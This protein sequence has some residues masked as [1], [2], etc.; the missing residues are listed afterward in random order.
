MKNFSKI[1][2]VLILFI[3]I[4]SIAFLNQYS[5]TE[6]SSEEAI[7]PDMLSIKLNARLYFVFGD[8]LHFEDRIIEFIDK[9]YAGGLVNELDK[10]PK[11]KIYD[12]LFNGDVKI[13]FLELK[14]RVAYID[15][16]TKSDNIDI[17][18]DDRADLFIWSIVNTFTEQADI[19][20]VK[21]LI[22]GKEIDHSV[23]LNGISLAEPL[24][25]NEEYIYVKKP[26][27]SDIL[28]EFLDNIYMKRFDIAYDQIDSKSREMIKYKDFV[29]MMEN[30]YRKFYNYQRGVYF[31]R[32]FQDNKVVHV[33]YVI[34][35]TVL[36]REGHV[37][38]ETA[39]AIFDE[40]R[41]IEEDGKWKIDLKRR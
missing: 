5:I 37:V 36:N 20:K 15:L 22:N 33:K 3:F 7:N 32:N 16:L 34:Y 27:P 24:S 31:T 11:N 35:E 39:N 8:K 10:G 17:W 13:R 12:T 21:F 25:R 2:V 29:Q 38:T 14:D 4:A 26:H 9:D 40:W 1:V 19:S 41:L 6:I 28:I 23:V 18:S 30:Y